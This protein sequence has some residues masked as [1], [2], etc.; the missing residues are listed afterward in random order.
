VLKFDPNSLKGY[1]MTP[2]D[3]R[4][5]GVALIEAASFLELSKEGMIKFP[6]DPETPK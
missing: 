5:L 2:G 1:A 3:A 4:K 6:D